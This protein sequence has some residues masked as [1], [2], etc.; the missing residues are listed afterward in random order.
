MPCSICGGIGHN[1]R[2]CPQREPVIQQPQPP[3]EP[4]PP[5]DEHFTTML[6]YEREIRNLV[7]QDEINN[8]SEE[9][10]QFTQSLLGIQKKE[11]RLI[12]L[13]KHKTA[14]IYLINGNQMIEDL[15]QKKYTLTY[16]GE[17][18]PR[19]IN[20]LISFTGYNYILIDKSVVDESLTE[21]PS[22]ML[23]EIIREGYYTLSD[24]PDRKEKMKELISEVP[25]HDT[26]EQ[27]ILIE[28]SNDE[29]QPRIDKLSPNTENLFS[30]LKMNYLIQQLIR[31]GGLENDNFSPIL[32]LHQ[33]IKLPEYDSVDL[34]AA[35]L[36]NEFT[37]VT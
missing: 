15:S 31:L 9:Y 19:T 23:S 24:I 2:T 7:V 5:V 26:M 8:L 25:V 22:K 18:R 6:N 34:E 16:I 14:E 13:D 32:E 30:L 27:N 28:Y 20:P 11:F 35:G 1:R 10:L 36:P 21:Y 33:D 29:L 17:I 3:V 4:R 12:N 37:N